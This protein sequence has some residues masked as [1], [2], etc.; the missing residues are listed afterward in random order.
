MHWTYA[1]GLSQK[2]RVIFLWYKTADQTLIVFLGAIKLAH[3]SVKEYLISDRIKMGTAAMF[4]IS[5]HMSH[6]IIAQICLAY[7]LHFSE[8]DSINANNLDC[9][10]F[11]L[12]AAEHWPMHFRSS[13]TTNSMLKGLW[14]SLFCSTADHAFVNWVSLKNPDRPWQRYPFVE[15]ADDMAHPLYYAS[16]LGLVPIIDQLLATGANPHALGGCYGMALQA[17]CYKNHIEAVKLLL[18]HGANADA[19]AGDFGT[20]LQAASVGGDIRIVS[21]LLASGVD[22]DAQSGLYGTALQAASAVGHIEVVRLLL[23]FGAD[24]NIPTGWFGTALQAPSYSGQIDILRLLLDHGA[25]PNIQGGWWGSALQAASINGEVEAIMLLLDC[26]ADVNIRGGRYG[27]ALQAAAVSGAV[28]IVAL[29]LDRGAEVNIQ[30]G[31]FGSALGAASMSF[32][33]VIEDFLRERGAFDSEENQ[34]KNQILVH[35]EILRPAICN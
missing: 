16:L 31:L 15:A 33:K 28:E 19:Q 29:L 24:I 4:H 18:D 6:S 25:D 7:L 12:Y 34:R 14:T 2:P 8:V 30:G 22:V 32:N 10:P 11:A 17:A 27:T 3:F 35:Q 13:D 5:E 9:F 20:A 21:I 26:G 1:Q 23:K